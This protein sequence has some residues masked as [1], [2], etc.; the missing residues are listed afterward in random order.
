MGRTCITCLVM[1]GTFKSENMKER[2][3]L[4]DLVVDGRILLKCLK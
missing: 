2:N 3:W 4:E 1:S